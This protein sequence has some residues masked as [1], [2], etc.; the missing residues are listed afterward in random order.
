MKY[1]F[2]ALQIGY[3]A[4]LFMNGVDARGDILERPQALAEAFRLSRALATPGEPMPEK[5][6]DVTLFEP[7]G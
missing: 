1:R 6:T 7:T 2:D 5:P 3:F 4:N